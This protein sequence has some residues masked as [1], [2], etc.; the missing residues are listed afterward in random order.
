MESKLGAM[1]SKRS[2]I[3]HQPR[4][5]QAGF[6]HLPRK[7]PKTLPQPPPDGL[8]SK[9]GNRVSDS[10]AKDLRIKRVFSP[11]LENRSSVP[12]GEPITANGSC[13]NEDSGVGKI[14][15]TTEVRND[16]FHNSNGHVECDK[17]RRCNGKSEKLVHSTP[18]DVDSLTG[19]FVAAS[20]RNGG[21]LGDTCAKSD[22]RIDSVARTG[23]VLKPCSK[24]KL[25]K[26]PGSIAYKRLLPFLLDSDNYMLQDDPNSKRENNLEKKANTE[27]NPCNHAKGSSFV[28]SDICVKDAIF[29][30]RMSSKT[31]KPNLPPPANGD[32]KN[33]QNGC[34]LNN[35][36]NIIKKDSGLTKDSVV[37][38]SSLE[39]RLTEHGVPT[40]YQTEDCS[41]KEQSKTSG[42]E[43][44]DGGTS[45]PSEVDNFKSHASEKLCNNVS[46]DIKREDHFNELK[47]SSLNSNIVCNPLKEERRDE[48][49]GCARGA[50]QKL[51][52]STVGENHCNI[53]TESDK[54][55]GTYVRNKMVCNPLVQL[56]SKYS[57]VSVSYRRMLPFLEDL[58]KDNP[59]NYASGNIDCSVQ[60]KELP[61]MNLQPPSSNSH[62][63]QDNSKDLVTCN[64]PFN[65]NSDTLSMPV[66]NSMNE[67]VCETDKVLLPDGV[68]DKLLSPPKL[69]LH[70][71][72]EMLDKCKLM[73]P[74]LPGATLL[75][76]QAVSS[77]YPAASYE[78]LTEEGS[79]LTSE[80]SPIT[81]ED[82]TS[83][84]D[85]ISDGANISEGNS[86]EPYS[87]CVEK[88][89]LP[90]SHI[91]LRKGIL[92]RNPRGCR[93]ICN[94]LNCSSFRLHAERAF[95]FSRNQLQDAEEVVTDLMKE[96]SFLRG[97]LEKYSD[98]AKGNA[99][100]HNSN[101][102]K[103]AC[104]KASEAELIA[105]DRLLQMNYE[106][107]IHCRIT[108]SQ[109][110]NV[111]LSSEVENIEIEDGK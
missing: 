90:E 39:E 76:D 4:A 78:P 11:N 22:C 75:N 32:T 30:S 83:L 58:F 84:K 89:I 38:I 80:Q 86:L 74:Q 27:S 65:G 63:S 36:Q 108:C 6:L 111:P 41:S 73:G 104:R 79:R 46:E 45:F 102:V 77:L 12:S 62:N 91:N 40:K 59:E 25:F 2:S 57:Q 93:G 98:G 70:S 105:K 68:N 52:S 61:T 21:V 55:Y 81:S 87:S 26:A 103:E 31:M 44:L 71:E 37:C 53:A 7:K 5:L 96:L 47:M 100:Y 94:C 48:K 20:S 14:S 69:Q 33:F 34:D 23:S 109:G 24:R 8:P 13:P 72:Q 60:E 67:T 95:E 66:L 9:D 88:C 17:D 28:D 54:K 19:G 50:D 85:N 101:N 3:T 16:N 82:C 92:K 35:S 18:P 42:M 29:A 51:G 10:F 99:E 97:V 15:D 43:R 1:A 110:P 49:V 64:M 56:K 107:G 106:L